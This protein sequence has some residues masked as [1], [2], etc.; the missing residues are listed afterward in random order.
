MFKDLNSFQKP[1]NVKEDPPF[2]KRVLE[3]GGS[4]CKVLFAIDYFASIVEIVNVVS[5]NTS[6][7]AFTV[8]KDVNMVTLYS[9]AI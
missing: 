7:R 4:L 5:S 8:S 1:T 9:V 2:P 6:N 3:K